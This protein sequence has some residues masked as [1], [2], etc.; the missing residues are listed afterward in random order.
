MRSFMLFTLAFAG[1]A[2]LADDASAFGRKKKHRG[3]D[4]C[5][6][7]APTSCCDA[8][9]GCGYPGTACGASPC[10]S[11][12]AAG[13]GWNWQA[14]GNQ[15]DG[16]V[17]RANDGSV[18]YRGTDGSYY[19]TPTGMVGQSYYGNYGYGNYGYGG[20]RNRNGY[21]NYPGVYQAGY[22]GTQYGPGVIT[23]GGVPLQMPSVP[24]IP[25]VV[26]NK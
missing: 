6:S 9:P 18:Y 20:Y 8:A 25:N 15:M 3:G 21:Y 26:P 23:V 1:L 14:Q 11:S 12:V 4:C 16:Q 17:I 7:P 24:G 13:P 2:A 22:P 10:D 19:T 5:D